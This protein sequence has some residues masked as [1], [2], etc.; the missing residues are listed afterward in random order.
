MKKLVQYQWDK[1]KIHVDSQVFD[2]YEIKIKFSIKRGSHGFYILQKKMT[3]MIKDQI[4]CPND[5]Q[6]N[7]CI[8]HDTWK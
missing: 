2:A 3:F 5:L 6:W 1:K 7:S 4:K 8:T